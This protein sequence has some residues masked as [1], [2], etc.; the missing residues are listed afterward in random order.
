M[1]KKVLGLQVEENCTCTE[2][3][4]MMMMMMMMMTMMKPTITIIIKTG[5]DD[6]DKTYLNQRNYYD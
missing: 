3:F 4:L 2:I 1:E 5:H 6:Y